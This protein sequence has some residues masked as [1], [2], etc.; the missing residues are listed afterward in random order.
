MKIEVYTVGALAENCYLVLDPASNS[1]ALVDPGAEGERLVRAVRDSGATLAAIWLTHAHVDHV[2]GIA[3]V[4][5]EWPEA[6]IYL[7]PLDAPIYDRAAQSAQMYGLLPFDSPPP[8][9]E[10]LADGA[11]LTLGALTFEAPDPERFP[12]LGL[13][14]A[15]LRAGGAGPAVFNAANEEAVNAFVKGRIGFLD[16]AAT[17]AETLERAEFGQNLATDGGEDVLQRALLVDRS[18]RRL[19]AEV[20]SRLGRAA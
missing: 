1:A 12:A 13:A 15:A 8:F 3:A 17:V 4:K 5:L 9:E 7:N 2:G 14:R 19:A 10:S 16:I 20:L 18:A 6:P 11:R